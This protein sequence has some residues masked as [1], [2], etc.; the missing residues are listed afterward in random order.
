MMK[1]FTLGEDFVKGAGRKYLPCPVG[2]EDEEYEGSYK[3][4]AEFF[5]ATGRTEEGLHGLI[6]M[7]EPVL[8]VP[9]NL[10]QYLENVNGEGSDINRFADDVVWNNMI[11][12]FGG[13]LV[14]APTGESISKLQAEADG[15]FPYM[16]E[17]RAE[18]IINTVFKT[19]NRQKVLSLVVLEEH[20]FKETLD[21]FT[22]EDVKRYRV[23]ELDDDGYYMES[24]YDEHDVL[25]SQVYPEEFGKRMK[26]IPFFFV[27]SNRPEKPL[28][29]DVAD[30][31]KAW[32]R[33]S[34]DLENGAHWTGVPTPYCIGYEPETKFDA[35]GNE[36]ATKKITL[37][38]SKIIYFPQGVTQVAY[39]EFTGSG[40]SQLSSLMQQDEERMAILGARIISAEKKGVESAETAK[41]HRAG[42][43][44]VLATF[45]NEVS[46]GLTKAL[47]C[48][49]EW[50]VASEITDEIS[51]QLNTD[52]DVSR[53]NPSELTALV[54]CWQSGGISKRVLFDNL[55]QGEIIGNGVDFDDM[56]SEID[57]EGNAKT[58]SIQNKTI[59]E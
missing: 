58:E 49:L 32:Y 55:K 53:M 2:M 11:T 18:Q 20:D 38:G 4:R 3:N 15:M 1:D 51:L 29:K 21:K 30:V 47:R 54:S 6:N 19:V 14:D 46:S 22:R 50:T 23:L 41:I 59:E 26:Y 27:L 40:L 37:G 5:N 42:E 39:L 25:I 57:E 8:N 17:Y 52:Y 34:A 24:V 12:G 35:N 10:K 44:G 16:T 48:Y 13:I 9:E 36:I 7:K 45:A 31:N 33:K 43:N 28:C 56:Q